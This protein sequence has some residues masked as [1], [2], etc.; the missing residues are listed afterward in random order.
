MGKYVI[1]GT[2]NG[3][4]KFDL[5][6]GNGQVIAS[7]QVYKALNSC[8]TGIAS[9]K[10]NAPVATIEDQTV[11][12][13]AKE[14]NPKFEIYTDK[15]GEFRFRMKAK[16]GQ[17]IATSEGYTAMKS[18]LNGIASIKKNADSPTEIVE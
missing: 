14:K 6:A 8:K 12:G 18:C 4:F 3:G 17:V 9:V 16:N 2:K 1:K 11:D 15:T 5:K 13:Y 10:T 7:S